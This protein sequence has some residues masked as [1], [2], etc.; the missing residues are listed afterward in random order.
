MTDYTRAQLAI[1]AASRAHH[2]TSPHHLHHVPRG[3]AF[4]PTLT[5]GNS[6]ALHYI[7]LLYILRC[8]MNN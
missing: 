8:E 2:S 3:Q 7:L 6:S 1:T 4:L 5:P